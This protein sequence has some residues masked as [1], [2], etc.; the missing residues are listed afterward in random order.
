MASP[1]FSFSGYPPCTKPHCTSPVPVPPDCELHRSK[2]RN[3]LSHLPQ[4]SGED[5]PVDQTHNY[6]HR[7]PHLPS[8]QDP[9]SSHTGRPDTFPHRR[10][11]S[12]GHKFPLSPKAQTPHHLPGQNVLLP[13]HRLPDYTP[14]CHTHTIFLLQSKAETSS[15]VHAFSGFQKL[16]LQPYG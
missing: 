11:T 16:P 10:A 9:D 8:W 13:L 7:S 1:A 6:N 15:E 12:P 4:K 14:C 5:I 3:L 2:I